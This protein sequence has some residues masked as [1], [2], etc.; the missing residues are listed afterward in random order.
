MRL[1]NM[2]SVSNFLNLRREHTF[3]RLLNSMELR[4]RFAGL[5]NRT[6]F[7]HII[8]TLGSKVLHRTLAPHVVVTWSERL[9]YA[10]R[11]RQE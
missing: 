9:G 6:R 2:M 1:H 7:G 8:V 5:S 4:R 3:E 10:H 11:I